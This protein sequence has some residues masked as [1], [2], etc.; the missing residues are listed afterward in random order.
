MVCQHLAPLENELI[1]SN[2]KETYRGQAWINNCREWV[3]FDAVLET[4]TL[5]TGLNLPPVLKSTKIL[6]QG[7]ALSV[8][9]YARTVKTESWDSFTGQR[10]F[11]SV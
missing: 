11:G 7:L 3:Y 4:A 1:K 10:Y 2:I 6:I 9:L 5:A 8:D